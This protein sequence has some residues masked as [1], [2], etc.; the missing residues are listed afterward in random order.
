MAQLMIMSLHLNAGN[1]TVKGGTVYLTPLYMK[2]Y[3]TLISYLSPLC[4][5][6][7]SQWS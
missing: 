5:N 1:I 2:Q 6:N 3:S 7:S 4:L